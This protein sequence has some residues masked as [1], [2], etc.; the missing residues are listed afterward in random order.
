MLGIRPGTGDF[1]Q[2]AQE[3][4]TGTVQGGDAEGDCWPGRARAAMFNPR[5]LGAEAGDRL[6]TGGR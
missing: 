6:G 1:V 5:D 4:A 2:G 3:K